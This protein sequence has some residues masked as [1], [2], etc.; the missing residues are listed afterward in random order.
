MNKNSKNRDYE[1]NKNSNRYAQTNMEQKQ[2][3]Q[4]MQKQQ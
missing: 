4:V 3:Q 1:I 2:K